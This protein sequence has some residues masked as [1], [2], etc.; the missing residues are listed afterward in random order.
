MSQAVSGPSGGLIYGCHRQ[1]GMQNR[2]AK[3]LVSRAAVVELIAPRTTK[4]GLKVECALNQRAY[5]KGIKITDAEINSLDTAATRSILNGTTRSI[6]AED[7]LRVFLAH[8]KFHRS[9]RVWRELPPSHS[10]TSSACTRSKVGTVRPSALA[11]LT[12]STVANLV[13]VCTGRSAGLSP[14]RMRSTYPA[15]RRNWSPKSGP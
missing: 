2:R 14:L 3:P 9:K 10:I 6:R 1:A 5:E 13:G 11:V 15:A 12:L 8:L 7:L 4:T